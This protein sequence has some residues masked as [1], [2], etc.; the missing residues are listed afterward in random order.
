[1]WAD[2]S[3]QQLPRPHTGDQVGSTP[4]CRRRGTRING[5]VL[6]TGTAGDTVCRRPTFK[7]ATHVSQHSRLTL[8]EQTG[9]SGYSNRKGRGADMTDQSWKGQTREVAVQRSTAWCQ[10][11]GRYPL[12]PELV[13]WGPGPCLQSHP[14]QKVAL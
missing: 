8:K 6:P 7:S 1:M 10:L 14:A 5:W 3:H 9:P 4:F 2:R 11:A 12:S 13:A